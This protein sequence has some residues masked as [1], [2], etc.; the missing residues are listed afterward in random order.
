MNK[1]KIGEEKFF[2]IV[3]CPFEG[4]AE[5][6]PSHREFWLWN[7]IGKTCLWKKYNLVYFDNQKKGRKNF[8]IPTLSFWGPC[9]NFFF[10]SDW[11]CFHRAKYIFSRDMFCLYH[12]RAKIH[13]VSLRMAW[14]RE[15]SMEAA[16]RI[17]TKLPWGCGLVQGWVWLA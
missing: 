17:N 3:H 2:E 10:L 5:L 9:W 4:W 11:V 12:F 15:S 1:N 7:D 14:G 6:H 13:G 16:P 8:W